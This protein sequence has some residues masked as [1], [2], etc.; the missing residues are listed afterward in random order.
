MRLLSG[1]Q[2]PVPYLAVSP[3][4]RTLYTAGEKQKTVRVWDLE[5][6]EVVEQLRSPGGEILSLACSADG[7]RLVTLGSG[8]FVSA[9]NL[10]SHHPFAA[11]TVS[12]EG[13][14]PRSIMT[15][16]PDASTIAIPIQ[17]SL[18]H[19]CVHLVALA[20]G[21]RVGML[22]GDDS[23]IT[24]LDWSPDGRWIAS[25]DGVRQLVLW[26]VATRQESRRFPLLGNVDWLAFSPGG[27][28]L[29]TVVQA[30]LTQWSLADGQRIG[31]LRL[32]ERQNGLTFRPSGNFLA[33]AGEDGSL[34][35]W[36]AS[37]GDLIG[38]K[39]VEIGTLQ[40]LVWLPDGSGLVVGGDRGIAICSCDE[41][42]GAKPRRVVSPEEPLCLFG[43]QHSIREVCFSPDGRRLLSWD[44]E[45][46]RCWDMTRG[47]GNASSDGVLGAGWSAGREAR[48]SLSPD[49]TRLTLSGNG[50][51]SLH[52]AATGNT[53][54]LPAPI[55]SGWVSLWFARSGN[56]LAAQ[57]LLEP[58][59]MVRLQLFD[60]NDQL[61]HCIECPDLRL[62][63]HR[64]ACPCPDDARL[65]L[66][67]RQGMIYRWTTSE[68]RMEQLFQQRWQLLD[69]VV[70]R[71]ERFV[72]SAGGSILTIWNVPRASLANEIKHD[73]SINAIALTP[74]DRRV[75]T[76][77]NDGIVRLWSLESGKELL[78]LDLGMGP[79]E[80]LAIAPDGMYF[81]AGVV[82]KRAIVLMDL[83]ED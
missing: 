19:N 37:T 49:G 2:K 38:Q 66:G 12:R 81:A 73:S 76:A 18:W 24:A 44:R 68:N 46:L 40:S 29:A 59:E 78:A 6:G 28:T 79:V 61:L 30:T 15:L 17:N 69:L 27:Q 51:G 39:Q 8:V 56:L 57:H 55:Q 16:S 7:T 52:D 9:W 25:S 34:R 80:T 36:D 83:P 58:T 22:T 21:E 45:T 71:N 32:P 47:A 67:F 64:S 63:P 62:T 14:L 72:V 41:V 53:L 50:S 1:Y 60:S 4:G 54:R 31:S 43:H 23:V 65:Y 20:T 82:K 5:R 74:D 70:T 26:E 3:D 35:I 11:W 42:I 48:V 13:Y 77:C 75:L 10:P 33:G